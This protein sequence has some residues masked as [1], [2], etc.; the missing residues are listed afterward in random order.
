MEPPSPTMLPV[1]IVAPPILRP[2]V[3]PPPLFGSP[4]A[5]AFAHSLSFAPSTV[6][7]KPTAPGIPPP[8]PL[9]LERARALLQLEGEVTLLRI[10]EV[11]AT[12]PGMLAC[13]LSARHEKADAGDLPGG[14]DSASAR[15]FFSKLSGLLDAHS[16]A[17]AA[18]ELQ[19]TTLFAR[20][21]CLSVFSAGRCQLGVIHRARVFL[22][23]VREKLT[24]AVEAL[25][26]A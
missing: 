18:S 5:A 22:P 3:A 8:A 7:E 23:G 17:L 9:N 24:A 1:R 16:G 10:A 21:F 19:H 14:F 26:E 13:V 12:L 20:Q 25:A 6:P 4:E 11:I 2:H 15:A